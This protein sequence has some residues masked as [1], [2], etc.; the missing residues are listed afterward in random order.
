MRFQYL[1][2]LLL[3]AFFIQSCGLFG[4]AAEEEPVPDPAPAPEEDP[5]SDYDEIV[6]EAESEEGLFTIHIKDQ[7]YYFEI[8]EYE[9][10]AEFLM[11]SRIAKAQEGTGFGGQRFNNQVLRWEKNGD[12]IN[13]RSVQYYSVADTAAT[14]YEAVENRT[15]EPII[16]TFDIEATSDDEDSYIIQIN[17]LFTTEVPELAPRQQFQGRRIDPERSYLDSARSFPDN[18]EIRNV[19]TIETESVPLSGSLNTISLMMNHSMV[20]LPE[21]PMMPRVHDERVGYFSVQQVDYGRH[22]HRA[23]ER[24]YITR[25]RLEKEDPDAELSEPKEPITFYV[26]RATP[27][28]LVDYVKEGVEDWQPAFEEAGFENAIVAKMAPSEE[29]DPDFNP[30]DARFPMV[31]WVPSEIPNAMGP[32]VHDPRSG[33]IITSQIFMY[34]NVMSLLRNWYFVQGAAVDERAQDLPFPDELMGRLVRYV[35]AHEVGHT[36]GHP[37]NMKASASV[38]TDSLRSQSFTEE[39]GTTPSIMDYA[40]MNYVAQPGDDAYMFPQVSVYDKFSIEWG[41]TPFD[42]DDPDDERPYLNEIAERQ[43]DEPMLRFGHLSM[44]DPTQQ[45]ESLGDN[46]VKSTTYGIKNLERTMDFIIE[47]AGEEGEDYS[48]LGELYS[49]VLQQRNRMLGHVAVWVGGIKSESK[50]YGQEG[51][52]YEHVPAYRQQEA[53]DYL[54]EE[55]FQTPEYLLDR[56]VLSLIQPSGSTDEIQQGQEQILNMLMNDARWKRM[57][58]NEVMNDEETYTIGQLL[59]DL[60]EGIWSELSHQQVD[61]DLFRRNLQRSYVDRAET[62]LGFET[63]SGE[64]RS[65]LR[66]NLRSIHSDVE[67][68]IARSANSETRYHLEDIRDKIEEVLD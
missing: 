17:R 40:R 16:A 4:T 5:T 21:E 56:E 27:E 34:H 31:R 53:V 32:H 44:V 64:T 29:E 18:I 22:E 3:S 54:N 20:R 37:H 35:V 62:N 60:E 13:L 47:A 59:G 7:D 26:D 28:W 61:I 33:E 9:L 41:Y 39:Y 15:F 57:A 50:V 52:V 24:R 65:M 38:P 10:G 14:I 8:P 45:R 2:L 68:A 58:E 23:A 36:L 6:D 49:N 19:L 43:E 25:W 51:A 11:V 67:S 1:T 48:D 63:L 42:V 66:G 46:H 30:N 12:K 55:A